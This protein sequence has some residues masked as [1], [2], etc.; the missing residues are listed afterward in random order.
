M[1]DSA[2]EPGACFVA[3]IAFFTEMRNLFEIITILQNE[4]NSAQ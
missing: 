2:Y 4:K 3:G 1:K